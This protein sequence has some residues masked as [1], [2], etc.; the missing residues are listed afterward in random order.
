MGYAI[1]ISIPIHLYVSRRQVMRCIKI[2]SGVKSVLNFENLSVLILNFW[3]DDQLSI[4]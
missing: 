3:L 4:F 2:K 1:P